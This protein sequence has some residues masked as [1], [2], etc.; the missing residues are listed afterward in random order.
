MELLKELSQF[1]FILSLIYMIFVIVNFF[2]KLYGRFKLGN[3]TKFTMSSWEKS[4]LLIAMSY[5]LSF[6]I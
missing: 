6:L 5:I 2:I 1:G 4:F 3:D